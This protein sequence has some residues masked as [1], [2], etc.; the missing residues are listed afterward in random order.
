MTSI[1]TLSDDPAL[2]DLLH[3]L[4]TECTDA[5]DHAIAGNHGHAAGAL[6]RAGRILDQIALHRAATW[7]I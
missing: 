6:A 5:L 1:P 2:Y 7:K 3:A 4:G